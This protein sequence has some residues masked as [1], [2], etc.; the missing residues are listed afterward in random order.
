VI[1]VSLQGTVFIRYFRIAPLDAAL[2]VRAP[3]QA[4]RARHRAFFQHRI[5]GEA[6]ESAAGDYALL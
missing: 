2:S 6:A 3:Q 5:E 4:A 1:E